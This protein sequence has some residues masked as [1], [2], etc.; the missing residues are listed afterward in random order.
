MTNCCFNP[1]SGITNKSNDTIRFCIKYKT[2]LIV[3][4]YNGKDDRFSEQEEGFKVEYTFSNYPT[5]GI[6]ADGQ[7][8]LTIDSF[9]QGKFTCFKNIALFEIYPHKTIFFSKIERNDLNYRRYVDNI[10][11]ISVI[12]GHDTVNYSTEDDLMKIFK[13]FNDRI[14]FNTKKSN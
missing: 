14:V 4:E 6:S 1:Y 11:E 2:P 5:I 12:Q 3:V 10:E 9:S 8:G 7:N 13:D